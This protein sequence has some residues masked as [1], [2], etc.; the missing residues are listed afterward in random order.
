MERG[1]V[2]FVIRN[3]LEYVQ[4]STLS[5][6]AYS[7]VGGSFGFDTTGPLG[8]ARLAYRLVAERQRQDYW[9]NDGVEQHTLLE[10]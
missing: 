2:I 3:Q 8:D 6:S 5:G 4:S 10:P 7:E 9:R 1:G